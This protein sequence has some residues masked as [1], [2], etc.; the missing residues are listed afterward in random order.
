MMVL[1]K[2]SGTEIK[3]N[4]CH[5]HT[6]VIENKQ[7]LRNITFSFYNETSEDYFVFSNNYETFEFHKK[8]IYIPS[9]IGFDMNNKKL[10][11]KINANLERL[12][13]DE[14]SEEFLD[15]KNKLMVLAERL[16]YESDFNLE[17]D[18]DI[19]PHDI[20]KLFGFEIERQNNNF[21]DDFIR[22][23]QLFAQYLGVTLIVVFG[24]HN[25]FVKEELDLIFNTLSLNEVNVLCIESTQPD[26]PSEYEKMHIIDRELCEIE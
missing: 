9:V 17:C 13:V 6:L 16:A 3:F 21:A 22:Y 4:N 7:L 25:F 20:V 19:N 8:G 1:F 18:Y 11:T 12:L 24:I 2:S 14:L 5:F 23:V 15:V 26:N 10:M